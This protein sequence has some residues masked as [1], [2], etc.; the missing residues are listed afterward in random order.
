MHIII[1]IVVIKMVS[2]L[3]K[4]KTTITVSLGTKNRLRDEK[5]SDSYEDFINYLLRIYKQKNQKNLTTNPDQDIK[6]FVDIIQHKRKKAV[7]LEDGVSF[8]YSYNEYVN[9]VA[10]H[11]DIQLEKIRDHGQ[12]ISVEG[13]F[14][15]QP[16]VWR[17]SAELLRDKYKLYFKILEHAIQ[18]EIDSMYAHS[19]KF[20]DHYNWQKE[21]RLLGLSL[22][23]FDEDVMEKLKGYENRVDLYD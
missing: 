5:G 19:G 17:S 20:E 13:Y 21:F 22:K 9:S 11:F 3:D 14:T 15:S 10:F 2:E 6:S 1:V 23:S 7:L 4:V 12:Q 16:K 8:T 18:R